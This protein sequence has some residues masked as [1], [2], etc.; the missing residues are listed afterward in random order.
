M[1]LF[2][3]RVL[4]YA[5]DGENPGKLPMGLDHIRSELERMRVQVGRQRK[6]ILNLQRAGISTASA[7]ALLSGCST[8]STRFVSSGTS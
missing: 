5:R 2:Y 1:G 4:F 6:E 7:E 8:R 3:P